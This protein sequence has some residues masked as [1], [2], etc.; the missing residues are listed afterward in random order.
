MNQINHQQL[1]TFTMWRCGNVEFIT[2]FTMWRMLN[3]KTFLMFRLFLL[4]MC[5]AIIVI[6]NNLAALKQFQS[7]SQ[8]VTQQIRNTSATIECKKHLAIGIRNTIEIEYE[9]HE[10][11][12]IASLYQQRIAQKKDELIRL[13]AEYESLLQVSS[14]QKSQITRV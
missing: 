11:L 14:V 1:F 5:F 6:N 10:S 7:L 12:K 4:A 9:D 13:K 2:T 8:R 3:F